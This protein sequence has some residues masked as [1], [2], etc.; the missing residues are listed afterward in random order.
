LDI[1]CTD[2]SA[3]VSC[4]TLIVTRTNPKI[5]ECDLRFHG[6]HRPDL[7]PGPSNP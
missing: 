3:I 2:F 1:F 4:Q 5:M 7:I 6:K